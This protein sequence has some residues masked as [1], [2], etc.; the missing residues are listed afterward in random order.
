[1]G[2]ITR[3]LAE[4]A[5]R[6]EHAGLPAPVRER[7]KALI[8]DHIA[9]AYRAR[10]E[11]AIC[12]SISAA[13]ERLGLGA[14]EASV[15]GDART[16][17]PPAAAFFNGALAHCLDFDDTHARASIHPSAPIVPAALAAAE[18]TSASGPECIA[19]ITAGYE[20]QIRLSLALGPFRTLRARLSSHRHLR[21][22]R[23]RGGRRSHPGTRGRGDGARLRAVRQSGR[24]LH[25]VSRR[26]RLEQALSRRIRGDERPDCGEPGE[27][28]VS[29]FA[30][31]AIEG[32]AGF[33]AS[34]APNPNPD[35]AVRNLGVEW[36]TLDIA[37]K[38]Y[39]SCR[40]GHAAMDA[41][42]ALR[43]EHGLDDDAVESVRIGLPQTGWRLI[44]DPESEKQNPR[45]YV[46][47]QFS[48]P[49]VAAVALREGGMSWDSYASHLDDPR[50]RSLCRRINSVVDPGV[51][52][53]FPAHMAGSARVRTRDGEELENLVVVAKGEPENFPAPGELRAKFNGLIGD[54]LPGERRV[55]LAEA[56]D[57]FEAAERAGDSLHM[58]RPREH[59]HRLR[60]SA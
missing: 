7:T 15:I 16:Y 46:D 45:N 33:L 41:L 58:S 9:I 32:R 52:S 53:H 59:E 31:D 13:L 2:D 37:V 26:R 36:E 57:A 44:G 11:A 24:G 12:P 39:P 23:R 8:A 1:M 51:E 30:A 40:Y 25:A 50:T 43:A 19:A 14:G 60:A 54:Y 29:R 6:I 3:R 20:V 49:F 34:Y 38:P 55:A 35:E 28:R 21:G 22:I 4:F 10:Q 18:M 56:L 47:G 42:I 17:A 27:R 48:M 5:S